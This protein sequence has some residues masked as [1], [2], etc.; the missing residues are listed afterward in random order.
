MLVAIATSIVFGLAPAVG[1]SGVA[2]NEAIKEQSR[3]VS[4]DSR[5]SIRNGL[6]V[7]QVALSLTLVVAAGLFARTFFA[8]NTRDVGFERDSVLVVNI[9]VQQSAV[10]PG[11]RR[12]L[13]RAAAAGGGHGP[14][15]VAR[16][17]LVHE[18]AGSR[19]A[20]TRGSRRRRA[21]R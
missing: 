8:L 15:R 12:E 11:Q 5:L 17:G 16:G 9:N 21:R 13:V 6:V 14:G 18:S 1:I 7:L 19:P 20:G 3:G 10:A 2:P 4:Y